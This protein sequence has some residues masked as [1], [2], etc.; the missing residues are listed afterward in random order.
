MLFF[1]IIN[2]AVRNVYK[3][4]TAID[5]LFGFLPRPH[6]CRIRGDNAL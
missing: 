1:V 3:T 2:K 6:P 5:Y 4:P